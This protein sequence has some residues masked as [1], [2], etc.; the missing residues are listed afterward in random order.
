M[1]H[2]LRFRQ[3]SEGYRRGVFE[4]SPPFSRKLGLANGLARWTTQRKVFG[5]PLHSQAVVRS[6]LAAMISRAEA[7]QA[8][9]ENITYQMCNMVGVLS[10]PFFQQR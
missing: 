8:W 5:K 10:M 7:A 1:G 2:V 3:K 4:V 9:L 6:K